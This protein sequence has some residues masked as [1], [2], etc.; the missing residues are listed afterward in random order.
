[1]RVN[2]QLVDA[3]SGAHLWAD[4]FDEDVADLFKLQDALRVS[5][6][7]FVSAEGIFGDRARH[8]EQDGR[9]A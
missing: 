9:S 5:L 2:A 3:A 7:L 6:R 8:V 4:Q 1:V